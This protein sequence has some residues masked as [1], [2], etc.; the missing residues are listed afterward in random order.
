M[1]VVFADPGDGFDHLFLLVHLDGVNPLEI[2][3]VIEPR[4][5]GTETLVHAGDLGIE[6]VFKPEEHGHVVPPG[7]D[8][9][10]DFRQVD[11]DMVLI[12][13]GRDDHVPPVRDTEISRPPLP[14]LI[15]IS[16]IFHRPSFHCIFQIHR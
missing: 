7:L 10:D 13:Q 15:K 3:L 5:G 14:D 2:P 1:V 6:D 12:P 4:D 9:G 11:G 16:G 8:P